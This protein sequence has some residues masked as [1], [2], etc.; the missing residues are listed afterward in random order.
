MLDMN[1]IVGF[2]VMLVMNVILIRYRALPFGLNPIH[3]YGSPGQMTMLNSSLVA[4][5]G[6][7]GNAVS[8]GSGGIDAY[9]LPQD[10]QNQILNQDSPGR[11]SML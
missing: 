4:T 7:G 6:S 5:V 2:T 9:T 11:F 3:E 10:V 8:N 1:V